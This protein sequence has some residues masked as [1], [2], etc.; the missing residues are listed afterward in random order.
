MLVEERGKM[1]VILPTLFP[2]ELAKRQF[3]LEEDK[4]MTVSEERG[5]EVLEREETAVEC[6]LGQV[7]ETLNK[8]TKVLF[9]GF[10]SRRVD[11]TLTVAGLQLVQDARE[12]C[13]RGDK[14]ACRRL[15]LIQRFL[16]RIRKESTQ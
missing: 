5:N 6:D 2:R 4:N 12:A 15:E 7:E 8:T 10:S 14:D 3:N 13:N 11:P 9:E 16:E 1:V